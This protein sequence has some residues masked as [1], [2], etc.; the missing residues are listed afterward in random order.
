[1]ECCNARARIKTQASSWKA[2]AELAEQAPLNPVRAAAWRA[3]LEK[4]AQAAMQAFQSQA[5]V[6]AGSQ[7][8]E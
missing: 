3:D 7:L 2:R 1:M 6:A 8:Q 4:V 5:Q